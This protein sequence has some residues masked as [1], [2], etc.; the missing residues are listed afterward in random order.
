[1]LQRE[2]AQEGRLATKAVNGKV[3]FGAVPSAPGH[4]WPV[5]EADPADDSWRKV[6]SG[7][8]GGVY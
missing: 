1:M 2:L 5:D 7:G 8:Q 4:F 6:G 3:K